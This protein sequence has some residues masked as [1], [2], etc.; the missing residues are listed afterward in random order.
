MWQRILNNAKVS[1]MDYVDASIAAI[2]MVNY[3]QSKAPASQV[4]AT[5]VTILPGKE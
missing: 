1:A 4:V 5:L 3:I 2:A